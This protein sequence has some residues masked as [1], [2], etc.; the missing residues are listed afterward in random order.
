MYIVTP[1]TKEQ[2]FALS[3]LNG[4]KHILLAGNSVECMVYTQRIIKALVKNDHTVNVVSH[5]PV[6]FNSD[7]FVSSE[8]ID[9]TFNAEYIIYIVGMRLGT[10]A[11]SM[12]QHNAIKS[13]DIAICINDDLNTY[14]LSDTQHFFAYEAYGLT[15]GGV[16]LLGTDWNALK[17]IE[18]KVGLDTTERDKWRAEIDEELFEDTDEV[19]TSS[20]PYFPPRKTSAEILAAHSQRRDS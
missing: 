8:T 20:T 13:Y 3:S 19:G 4:C 16:N 18:R 11:W 14:G 17:Q 12:V 9:T 1:H 5:M 6:I 2:P 10:E 7:L 15:R